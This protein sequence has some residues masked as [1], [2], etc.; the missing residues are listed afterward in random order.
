[1]LESFIAF[2]TSIGISPSH[3]FAGLAG[4]IVRV[5]IQGG[6][7]TWAVLSA[8][9]VGALCAIYLTP[10]IGVWFGLNLTNL[11][12]NN[13]LAFGI[14]MIGMSLSEGIV[15][16]A[17]NWAKNPRLM[18]TLDAKGLADAVNDHAHTREMK[19]PETPPDEDI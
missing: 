5:V 15:R 17:Q 9:I 1:M 11:S 6:A 10:I 12:M 2:L 16:M 8:S 13:G 18:R 19:K 4:A 3:L 14:G 7:L